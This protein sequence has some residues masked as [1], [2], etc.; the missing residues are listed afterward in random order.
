M[1]IEQK[2]SRYI[3]QTDSTNNRLKAML[4]TPQPPLDG[5]TLYTYYQTAGRGQ[6]GNSW[7]SEKD[8]NLLFSTV[9]YPTEL[10]VEHQF[11]ISQLI[12]L[13]LLRTL[14]P[15]LG[16]NIKIK[17][18]NDIYYADKKLAGI[19]VENAISNG[20]IRWSVIGVGL[21]VNQE[22]FLSD[23]PNPISMKQITGKEYDKEALLQQILQELTTLRQLPHPQLAQQYIDNLYRLGEWHRF[24]PTEVT[25]KPIAISSDT[26]NA[27]EAQIIDVLTDG[28][29]VLLDRKQQKSTYHFKQ[30]RYVIP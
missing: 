22:R 19:L 11:V 26:T 7:E 8:K 1:S 12:A 29:I 9:I 4:A 18:P 24:I 21:N 13:A 23:A 20:Q 2:N 6:Q 17:W 10:S 3:A 15:I 28:R 16:D 30:L 25:A 14:M 5:Y 27:F